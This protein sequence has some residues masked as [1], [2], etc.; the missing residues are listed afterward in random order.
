MLPAGESV[1]FW[2]QLRLFPKVGAELGYKG[3]VR[4]PGRPVRCPRNLEAACLLSSITAAGE[5][6]TFPNPP[7]LC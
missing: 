4:T 7:R 2:K 5:L 6:L 3:G 1:S